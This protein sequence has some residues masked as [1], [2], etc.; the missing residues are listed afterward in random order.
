MKHNVVP[1]H[2]MTQTMKY[3]E[4]VY[5]FEL[6]DLIQILRNTANAINDWKVVAEV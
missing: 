6:T 3:F 4:V 5:G 1:N 2:Q